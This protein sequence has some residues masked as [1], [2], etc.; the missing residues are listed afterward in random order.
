VIT[1]AIR[2]GPRMPP[3]GRSLTRMIVARRGTVT[4]RENAGASR[5]LLG[6]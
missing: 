3:R 4:K 1:P 5:T 6:P 2:I